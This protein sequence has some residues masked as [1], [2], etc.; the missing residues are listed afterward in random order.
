MASRYR[1]LCSYFLANESSESI[2]CC[3][4]RMLYLWY[5]RQSLYGL[6]SY[7]ATKRHASWSRVSGQLPR[8]KSPRTLA[9]L[10]LL[11]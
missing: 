3:P 7:A 2:S 5:C 11:R 4:A 1:M 8:E 10:V 9:E 6:G